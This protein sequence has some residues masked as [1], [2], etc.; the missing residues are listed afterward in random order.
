MASSNRGCCCWHCGCPNCWLEH[1]AHQRQLS[2][3]AALPSARTSL[4][5]TQAKKS[6]DPAA[7]EHR[8]TEKECT[9]LEV[10]LHVPVQELVDGEQVLAPIKSLSRRP[11]LLCCHPLQDVHAHCLGQAEHCVWP[12]CSCCRHNCGQGQAGQG[13]WVNVV[14]HQAHPQRR[15][16]S[17]GCL[18]GD[19][20]HQVKDGGKK[21]CR[22]GL[23]AC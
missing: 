20:Q 3:C 12:S 10:V 13:T 19:R 15:P 11:L 5:A 2:N 1:V 16:S 14:A 18:Q 22:L 23:Q 9:H 8:A 4:P 21:R 6:S 17:S 7:S